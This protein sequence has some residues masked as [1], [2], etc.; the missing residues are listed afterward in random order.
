MSIPIVY[1]GDGDHDRNGL[2]YTLSAYKPLIEWAR[3]RWYDNHEELP[4][5]HTRSQRIQVL[6]DGLDRYERMRAKVTASQ[7]D[8]WLLSD[9][10]DVEH[11]E[12]RHWHQHVEG[13]QPHRKSLQ[14]NFLS[15]VD[16][17]VS[18]LDHLTDGAITRI[19]ADPEV[20]AQWKHLWRSELEKA[21]QQIKDW[22]AAMEADAGRRFDAEALAMSSGLSAE[23]V[24]R[25][26]LND[27]SHPEVSGTIAMPYDRFNPMKPIPLVRPLVV[28]ARQGDKVEVHFENSLSNRRVG[29]HLQGSGLAGGTSSPKIRKGVQHG[30]GAKVGRNRDTTVGPGGKRL[31]KWSTEHEGVWLFNDLAD[32][33]GDQRGTN[34]HGLFGALIIEPAGTY[35]RDS[36]TGE[37]LTGTDYADGLYVDI[38]DANENIETPGHEDF[39]DFYVDDVAR[40]H[41]EYTIFIHDESE[42]HSAMHGAHGGGVMPLSYRAEPMPNRVPH[43]M[44]R[45]AEST[46]DDVPAGQVGIDFSAVRLGLDSDLNETYHVAR[47]ADGTF[48]EQVGGEEQHHSSWLFG[49]P[50]T[51]ILYGYKGDPAR[52]RVVHAGVKETPRLSPPRASVA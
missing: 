44:R 48:L 35:W 16:D 2:I 38:I 3:A 30:D 13:V 45:Y 19:D 39:V 20:R 5:V 4:Q 37:T 29:L 40:S 12:D 42:V 33:R 32:L 27:H 23:R 7:T 9:Y 43:M 11:H 25:L 22:F 28:R 36:E 15:T 34:A 6:L 1:T 51:P 31:F 8:H 18:Q 47:D 10:G 49:D 24:R 50:V 46:P 21:D 41:R 17:V 52:I 26:L 14:Q